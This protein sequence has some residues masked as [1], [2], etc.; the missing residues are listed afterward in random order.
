MFEV[1]VR[2]SRYSFRV[3]AIAALLKQ[4]VPMDEGQPYCLLLNRS[5]Q[6]FQ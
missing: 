2:L 1:A 4:G 6:A 5:V 3:T